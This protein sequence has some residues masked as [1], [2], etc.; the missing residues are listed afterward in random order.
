MLFLGLISFLV[1]I[2]LFSSSITSSLFTRITSLLLF[3]SA[4]LAFHGL[5]MESVASGVGIYSGLFHITPLSLGMETFLLIIGGILLLSW[6]PVA[7]NT[8]YFSNT[9]VST[10]NT[11][12]VPTI[13][14]YG[15]LIVFTTMG[16]CFLLTSSDLVSM[17]LSIEL[18]SFAVYILATLYRTSE[19]A[20]SAGLKYFLLGG[21]SSALILL[22][23]AF[24]YSSTGLTQFESIYSLCQTTGSSASDGIMATEAMGPLGV[25]TQVLESVLLGLVLIG[26]GLLFKVASAPFHNWAPDVYDGVPTI[27]TSWLATMPKISIFLFLLELQSGL[28]GSFSIVSL[29]QSNDALSFGPFGGEL[30]GSASLGNVW[31]NL[32]LVASLLSLLIGT[33]L[34]LS[35]YRIKRLL[36]Y[37][38]ISHVG[39]LL[40]ALAI[41]TEDSVESFLFYLIQYSI[42]NAATFFILLA[43]GYSIYT[44]NSMGNTSY[45]S[46]SHATGAKGGNS[47]ITF[48]KE[49]AGQFKS[50]PL[51]SLSLALCLFSM[52]GIPPLVGFFAKQMVLYSSMHAGYHFLSIVAILVS[53]ISASYYLKIVRILYFDSPSAPSVTNSSKVEASLSGAGDS[54][55]LSTEATT[56]PTVEGNGI[57]NIHSLLIAGLTMLIT[58]F[59]LHPSPLLNSCYLLALSLFY[60]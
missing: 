9:V 52:A 3:F 36:A 29:L 21:L 22:G 19:S 55:V 26:V 60:Y 31:K 5:Y 30:S 39:F 56:S 28:G 23:T 43:F 45:D 37:S 33:V 12:R 40:L 18:Q 41:N 25:S 24:I 15:L 58:F 7:S 8:S 2:P 42:T 32:L 51:L 48:T 34:G 16:S 14:E 44:S 1:A 59:I 53:V 4:L 49:L 20:T 47:D 46:N 38:T 11:T 54:I 35:Q 10:S 17:Y 27:V 57:T 50:N 13:N 6:A